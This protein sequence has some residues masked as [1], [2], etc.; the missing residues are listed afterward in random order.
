VFDD[1]TKSFL[2]SNA[3]FELLTVSTESI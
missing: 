1:E 2:D 3:A